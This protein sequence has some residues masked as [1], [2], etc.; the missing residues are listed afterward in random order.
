MIRALIK[1]VIKEKMNKIV[2]VIAVRKTILCVIGIL[3]M[4]NVFQNVAGGHCA[5]IRLHNKLFV[6]VLWF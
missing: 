1:F 4:E 6:S 5:V 2:Q 3:Q